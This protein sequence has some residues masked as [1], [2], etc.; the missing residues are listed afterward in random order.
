MM[1]PLQALSRD[2]ETMSLDAAIASVLEKS[3]TY[4]VGSCL[5]MLLNRSV[6]LSN[7]CVKNR[8]LLE[9][10]SFV[11]SSQFI[12]FV[13]PGMRFCVDKS[14]ILHPVFSP[15]MP[16]SHCYFTVNWRLAQKNKLLMTLS[17]TP[18]SSERLMVWYPDLTRWLKQGKE[19]LTSKP[20]S[21]LPRARAERSR[22]VKGLF[23]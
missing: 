12:T 9:N 14:Q 6:S 21:F 7:P 17:R 5:N 11:L 20:P 3:I 2:P 13:Y 8:R 19:M 18:K 16:P 10:E 22:F 15:K 4:G 23:G 1:S